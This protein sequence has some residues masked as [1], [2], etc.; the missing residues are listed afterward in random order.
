MYGLQLSD[1]EW[2]LDEPSPNT[3]FPALYRNEISKF[4]K[5]LFLI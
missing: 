1:M 5:P 3:S 2:K 4:V